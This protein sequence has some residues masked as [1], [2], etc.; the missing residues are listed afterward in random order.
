[1]TGHYMAASQVSLSDIDIQGEVKW[2]YV[3]DSSRHGFCPEC[4]SQIF[5]RNDKNDFLSVTAGSMQDT[6][7]LEVAGHVF[8]GEKGDYYQISDDEKRFI[9]WDDSIAH[10]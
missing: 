3:S 8:V 4:G 1:M 2:H 6:S 10:S 5:W 9:C 7:R